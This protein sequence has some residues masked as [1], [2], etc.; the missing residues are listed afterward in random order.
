[1]NFESR[2]VRLDPSLAS[3]PK[4]GADIAKGVE[5]MMSD[6][7]AGWNPHLKLEFLK[8]CIRT[9][10][11]KV[12]AEKK[13]MDKN[14]E[15]TLN[16][17]LE[18]AVGELAKG[19]AT[20]TAGTQALINYIEELRTKKSMIVEEKGRKLAARLGTKWYNEGEKSTRYFLRLLNRTNPDKF[21]KIVSNDGNII[22]DEVKIE[23]EIKLFYKNLYEDFSTELIEQNDV[24][25]FQEIEPIADSDD[26]EIGREISVEELRKT[27]NTCDDSSPGPDG[28]PYSI[29]GLVWNI[30]GPT[31]ASAWKYSV[32]NK[33]LPPSH[34]VSYLKLIPKVGKDQG[35]L[36]NWRPI[37]LSNCDHKLITKTYA[38]RMCEKLASKLGEGQ[39]AYLKGRLINDN[40]RALL[41]TV[42]LANIE[43]NLNG[44]IVA[45][46][47]KKAFDSVSHGYIEECL[48]K[49]GCMSFVPIFKVLH[50]DL[51][52][53]ILFNGRIIDGFLIK[54]GVKQGD[55]LS[56][57]LFIMCMELRN[58]DR[59]EEIRPLESV[60]L[61]TELPKSYAYAD[62]VS[63]TV[64]DDVTSVNAVFKE[65][66]RLTKMSGL[67][68]N[69][70]KTELMRI[71]IRPDERSYNVT[72]LRSSYVIRSSE[73]IKLNGIIFHRDR[74][75]MRSRN[76]KSAVEK[77]D[78]HF[79]KWSRRNL[80]TLGKI[81]IVKCF[82]I[83]QVTYL[84]QT[85]ELTSND[86]KM[87]N[88][89][90]YKFIWN[91]RYHAAKAPERVK[92]E[93]VNKSIK[94]GGFGMLDI[95][96]LDASLK[97]KSIGRL[98]ET[99]HPFLSK[100]KSKLD[101]CDF[102]EPTYGFK[103]DGMVTKGLE[104]L[105]SDRNKL[106]SR[107]DLNSH[108]NLLC[109]I[110]DMPIKSILSKQG[111]NSLV[112]YLISRQARKVSHLTPAQLS[113]LERFVPQEKLEKIN[114]AV[115]LN[116]MGTDRS[117][118]EGYMLGYANKHLSKCTSKE[119]RTQR[120]DKVPITQYKVGLALT[121]KE[122]LSWGLKI[123]KLTNIRHKATLLRVAHGD[124]YTKDKLQRYGLTTDDEC[125][126]CSEKETLEHKVLSCNYASRIWL[127]TAAI[128]R[129][130]Q[131]GSLLKF[132]LGARLE[133]SLEGLTIKAEILT[134]ILSLR[135]DQNYLIH[136]RSLVKMA[137]KS[138][139]VKENKKEIKDNLK[140]LLADE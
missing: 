128:L 28:I 12:Q 20:T 68:L 73:S 13:K 40:L 86:L 38:Q 26:R 44:L 98:F 79:R 123:S 91:R 84:M 88:A 11:E 14:E 104:L 85:L 36:T 60:T 100:I 65:Y 54:R 87:I 134:R 22:T 126:R 95:A 115:G 16:E 15:E 120:S 50:K 140:A 58:I 51:K 119:I 55:A 139:S 23:D 124:V 78:L 108:K 122:A 116:L 99:K 135:E 52:T 43:D 53:D 103:T 8:V 93:F 67:E 3:D 101:L 18:V 89:T 5:D 129:E 77:M 49:F 10:V 94:L 121:E 137:I 114:L 4:A 72:Y 62:D 66:E 130:N 105:S 42:E 81:L 24:D 25:F 9:T 47:A 2:I 113:Q 80:T 21:T 29:I 70:D 138:L 57:I 69:A 61:G 17:E 76:I 111:R 125:P 34:K 132:I 37:T 64:Q 31:L 133:Q 92:R 90:L 96:E 71:G 106:W 33:T 127:E 27:L 83:S 7:P 46:D 110:R 19:R 59:N 56:C 30:F 131:N 6:V 32:E 41:S 74:T 97:I 117:F 112:F 107:R 75:E 39:T 1:M 102:F 35:K 109:A 63:C 136:P 45:L 118:Y 82:G 48:K